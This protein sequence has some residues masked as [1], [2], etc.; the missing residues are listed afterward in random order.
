[1]YSW[2]PQGQIRMAFT[3]PSQVLGMMNTDNKRRFNN[4]SALCMDLGAGDGRDR[5][6]RGTGPVSRRPNSPDRHND[7]RRRP[8]DLSASIVPLVRILSALLT[9]LTVP[10]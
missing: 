10:I 8:H 5:L 9:V 3:G 7:W 6:D 1:M 4:E 2:G